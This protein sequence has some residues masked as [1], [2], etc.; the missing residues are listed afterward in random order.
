MRLIIVRHGQ[1]TENATNVV[2]GHTHGSLSE[3]GVEQ[4]GKV[5]MRLKDEE[6]DHIY[7]SDLKRA[8][9]TAR[10]IARF[11]KKTPFT[12]TQELRERDWGAYDNRT[13]EELGW[14]K[15]KSDYILY[16][17]PEGGETLEQ[18]LARAEAFVHR[19]LRKHLNDTV[20]FVTHNEMK[21]ALICAITG[22][23]AKDIFTMEKADNTAVSIFEIEEDRSHKIHVL[24]CAKHLE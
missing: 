18:M 6:I 17:E 21:K 24:R 16:A 22:K 4:A 5:A 10:E 1:T 8:E 15:I 11:H 20:L 14:D 12:P 9:D 7:C 13:K 19:I 2:L 3:H 23:P